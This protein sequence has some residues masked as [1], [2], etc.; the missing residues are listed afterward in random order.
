MLF[1]AD[2][3]LLSAAKMKAR[4]GRLAEAEA[5]ARRALL[6]RLKDQG[7]YHPYTSSFLAGLSGHPRRGRPIF[8]SGKLD[9]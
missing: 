2:A 4:Q 1:A 8:R 7:K 5:D 3:T 9:A 6:N